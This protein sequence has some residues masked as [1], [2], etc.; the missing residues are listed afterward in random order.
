MRSQLFEYIILWHPTEDSKEGAKS[1]VIKPA[2]TSL[3]IDATQARTEAAMNIPSEY[4]D[5]LDQVE[6]IVRPF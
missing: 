5:H 4:K 2:T 6:I 1:L 3:A